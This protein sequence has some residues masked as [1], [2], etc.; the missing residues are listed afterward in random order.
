MFWR[1]RAQEPSFVSSFEINTS[2]H[3]LVLGQSV[4]KKLMVLDRL[5]VSLAIRSEHSISVVDD[6]KAEYLKARF[7]EEGQ[8]RRVIDVSIDDFVMKD[9]EMGLLGQKFDPVEALETI[10]KLD[11]YHRGQ[12]KHA[13]SYRKTAHAVYDALKFYFTAIF[14]EKDGES[15]KRITQR[16]FLDALRLD[17]VMHWLAIEPNSEARQSVHSRLSALNGFIESCELSSKLSEAYHDIELQVTYFLPYHLKIVAFMGGFSRAK[18]ALE[19]GRGH[20]IFRVSERAPVSDLDHGLYQRYLLD[21]ITT[22]MLRLVSGPLDGSDAGKKVEQEGA[23]HRGRYPIY[24]GEGFVG[25]ALE[26]YRG[27]GVTMAQGRA[28]GY[29]FTCEMGEAKPDNTFER[30]P[31]NDA[32]AALIAN[33]MTT[34]CL[35]RDSLVQMCEYRGESALYQKWPDENDQVLVH[36]CD[37]RLHV[38]PLLK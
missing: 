35:T 15:I 12:D 17:R 4:T 28:S 9:V 18:S 38:F 20:I 31:G 29:A 8:E 14:S 36:Q 22:H 27:L 24:L 3:S 13:E 21:V 23:L 2:N 37:N 7:K 16:E 10:K 5:L 26:H 25:H 6:L 33:A 11:N 19:Q 1:S 30:R 34:I 32:L